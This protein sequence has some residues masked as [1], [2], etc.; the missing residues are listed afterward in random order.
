MRWFKAIDED[1]DDNFKKLDD[2]DD[3]GDG[4]VLILIQERINF[5]GRSNNESRHSDASDSD[6]QPY[7]LSALIQ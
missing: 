5:V 6:G 1:D 7:L 4:T 2:D 3:D